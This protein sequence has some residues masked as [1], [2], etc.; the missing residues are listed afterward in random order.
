MPNPPQPPVTPSDVRLSGV[1]VLVV[2]DRPDHLAVVVRM[3]RD[4]GAE[5]SGLA[6]GQEAFDEI[7]AN[8]PDVLILDLGLPD[9]SG[10]TLA[11]RVREFP[12]TKGMSIVAFTAE[13]DRAKRDEAIKNG[14]EY[15]VSKPDFVRLLHVVA[16]AAGR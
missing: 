13:T 15:F 6:S 1:R 12:G 11:R 4:S 16:H 7:H 9:V 8:P 10:L 5:V 3:L 14:V 2:E